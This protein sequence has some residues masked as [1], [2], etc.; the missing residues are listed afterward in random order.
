M[1]STNTVFLRIILAACLPTAVTA[2]WWDDFTNNLATDLTP[3]IALFGE[4][5]TKQFLSESTTFLDNFLFAMAPLGIL[6]GVVSAIRVC[7][8]PS[9]RAF[10]GRAQEGGGIAEA[11]LCSSTS[12]DVCELYHNGAIVRVFGRPKILEIVHDPE[13]EKKDDSESK[14]TFGINISREYFQMAKQN[15]AGWEERGK[16]KPSHDAENR[17]PPTKNTFDN[18]APNPNLSLNIGI[19]KRSSFVY[20]GAAFVGFL[21]QASVLV[22]SAIITYKLH[23]KKNGN[24]MNP[25]AFP[26]I[27]VGTIFVCFGMFLCATL[28]ND[29]TKE[30]VSTLYVVQ[31]GNQVVGDQTFDPFLFSKP[32]KR[33]MTSWKVAQTSNSSSGTRKHKLSFNSFK[34]PSEE[35]SVLVATIITI[36]GFALQ[37]VGL[38]AMHSIVSLLQLAVILLMSVIRA[39]L[40][41]QRLNIDENILRDRPD[42][43]SGHELDWMALQMARDEN[44]PRYFWRVAAQLPTQHAQRRSEDMNNKA[45]EYRIRLAELTGQSKNTK[46]NLSNAW[47]NDLVSGRLQAQQLKKAIEGSLAILE[48]HAKVGIDL[49]NLSWTLD[50]AI[51]EYGETSY[52][53]Q[54]IKIDIQRLDSV[55]TVDPNHLEAVIGLWSWSIISDPRTEE[56]SFGLKTSTAADKPMHWAITAGIEDEIERSWREIQFWI[57]RPNIPLL[58]LSIKRPRPLDDVNPDGTT[59]LEPDEQI[60]AH[61][62]D[63]STPVSMLNPYHRLF[64]LHGIDIR[65][66]PP[67]LA[68]T[69]L[70]S[71]HIPK[72]CSQ[73]IYQSFLRTISAYLDFESKTTVVTGNTIRLEHRLVTK[74]IDCLETS[75]LGSRQDASLIIIPTLQNHSLL[76]RTTEAIP[77]AYKVAENFRKSDNFKEAEGVL[78][79]VWGVMTEL[80]EPRDMVL[81]EL[82]ELYRHALFSD[83]WQEF[84][85]TGIN[86][87][88]LQQETLALSPESEVIARYVELEKRPREA[89]TG[90]HVLEAISRNDRIETLWS[91]SQ[92][93]DSDGG[94]PIDK[95]SGRSVL[96]FLCEK[97][98]LELVKIT[99]EIGSVVDSIDKQGR[100]PL[101]YA[102]E[103]GHTLIV[104]ILM[105]ANAL[106]IIEDSFRR[107]PL[108]YAAAKGQMAV[109]EKLLSDPRVH[110]S[111]TDAQSRSPLHWAAANGHHDAMKYLVDHGASVHNVDSNEFTPLVA[112]LLKAGRSRL[113]RRRTADLLL[114]MKS[115]LNYIIQGQELLEWALQ[116][117]EFMCVEYILEHHS[118]NDFAV[119]VHILAPIYQQ[120][121]S[122]SLHR[123]RDRLSTFSL[124]PDFQS[125]FK[126]RFFYDDIE[127][128]KIKLKTLLSV[129]EGHFAIEVAHV[130]GGSQK[131]TTNRD[132]GHKIMD[133]LLD[134]FQELGAIEKLVKAAATNQIN[135]LETM[136]ILFD[137]YKSQIQ[138]TEDL[139]EAAASSP[140]DGDQVPIT[141]DVVKAAAGNEGQ[142]KKIIELLLDRRGDQIQITEDVVQAAAYNENQGLDLIELLLDRRGDQVPITEDV[143]KAAA[144]NKKYGEEIIKFL[145]YKRGNQIP[146]TEDVVKAAAGNN[147]R[148]KQIVKI[149]LSW[150]KDQIPITEN[151][152][153]TAAGN[154]TNGYRI[155]KLLLDQRGGQVPITE[156]IIKAAAS[157]LNNAAADNLNDGPGIIKLLLNR[158]GDQVLIT[159][160]IVKIAATLGIN[161]T[162]S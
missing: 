26:F 55:W 162:P 81:L 99:L 96:S 92:I 20:I 138:L 50:L 40:R 143:A 62:I 154:E 80:N 34:N 85:K 14:N 7:G 95:K 128:E 23:W 76:P 110:T 77:A 152:V 153:K 82:G 42:E 103:Q 121:G 106:P 68:A 86:W 97:G 45:W 100:T 19:V 15:G 35:I 3:L 134:E 130:N 30:R 149:F 131:W 25:W 151:V 155:I 21:A 157:N 146:I 109:I 158:R 115:K 122:E 83:Q 160:D 150:W 111:T 91:I 72:L 60:L 52:Q 33:Y 32:I 102:A 4:Q 108:S 156:D 69:R 117:G 66:G 12:R 5:A 98:W 114:Q 47:G 148:G 79:W 41:T 31:P 84:G 65:S 142:G 125:G 38:R 145:F 78:R 28:V 22:L 39:L 132:R 48:N 1:L 73:D 141:E 123:Y 18:F 74:L 11:E 113:D 87:M 9:L 8:G 17:P 119:A 13:L 94:L 10:I 105:E 6:T 127:E 147:H 120:Y 71:K 133:M 135:A 104:N 136:S 159:E 53:T 51:G 46:S 58:K 54:S 59:I 49:A 101:S 61:E 29:S 88:D 43:V 116:K 75:G 57:E 112:A 93:R 27:F 64:G 137:R 90:Q 139:V 37:F 144:G 16:E 63:L 67:A 118:K 56:V 24:S 107:S 124:P 140:Y 161:R 89:R 36:L 44:G 70:E 2:S 129:A 126:I